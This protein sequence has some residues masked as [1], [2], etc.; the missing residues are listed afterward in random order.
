MPTIDILLATYNGAKYLPALFASLT[1]QSFTDW[2]IIV[3]DDG[4]SD[5][6]CTI[7]S[8]WAACN[9]GRTRI[10][11]S[12]R[13]GLG[14]MANFNELLQLS[15]APYFALC[16]QDDIWLPHKLETLLASARAVE[17]RFGP[18]TPV[19]VHSDLTVVDDE[20][21]PLSQSLWGYRRLIRP[22]RGRVC[23]G[24]AL[25]NCVTGCA[26][27]GNAALR[28]MALPIPREA[29][30][31]DWWLALVAS[32]LGEIAEVEEATVLYRQHGG[33]A[34]GAQ[35]WRTSAAL[36]RF[37]ESPVAA[38]RRTHRVL[39]GTQQ[40]ATALLDRHGQR[41]DQ[42]TVE[43]FREY[44]TLSSS[45]FFRRKLFPAR[46]NLWFNGFLRNLYFVLS[47]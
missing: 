13:S 42:A 37:A 5:E 11:E 30:M 34:V 31:H 28:E 36:M 7:V 33:N 26:S 21:R 27:I 22:Q 1:A 4:S 17:T 44:A 24:I 41:M 39:A 3:R 25:Q 35:S 18:A 32:V 15:D 19:L 29:M 10:V 46:Y 6:T 16:D 40:Q 47:I 8:A 12:D 45:P 43:F 20:L 23:R 9:P 14:A 2:R 38:M